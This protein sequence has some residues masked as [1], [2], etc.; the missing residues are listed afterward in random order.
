MN[1]SQ[2]H[3]ALLSFAVQG[4]VFL[5]VSFVLWKLAE[6]RQSAARS[7]A[8]ARLIMGTSLLLLIASCFAWKSDVFTSEE[9]PMENVASVLPL[10][11]YRNNEAYEQRIALEE[12]LPS[13]VVLDKSKQAVESVAWEASAKMMS[14]L[15]WIWG[16]GVIVIL[17][18]WLVAIILR[19]RLARGAREITETSLRLLASEFYRAP[20]RVRLLKS[21]RA[22]TPCAYGILTPAIL[23]PEDSIA[24]SEAKLRMV[25]AHECEHLNRRDPFWQM[26]GQIFLAMHWFNPFAWMLLR[27]CR[28]ANERAA[29]DAVLRASSNAASYAE[30]LLGFARDWARSG[31]LS[32]VVSSMASQKS[33]SSRVEAILDDGLD[34]RPFSRRSRALYAITLLTLVACVTTFISGPVEALETIVVNSEI[35]PSSSQTADSKSLVGVRLT[36]RE[37]HSLFP[38]KVMSPEGDVHKHEG[39]EQNTELGGR[40]VGGPQVR[41]S[42]SLPLWDWLASKKVSVPQAAGTGSNSQSFSWELASFEGRP[43]V[44]V[45]QIVQFY[46]A[47]S[48]KAFMDANDGGWTSGSKSVRLNGGKFNLKYPVQIKDQ[49]LWL[50]Q[51]DLTTLLNPVFQP[52]AKPGEVFNTV[53]I[54]PGHGGKDSG[55]MSKWGKEST[56]TLDTAKRLQTLLEAKGLKVVLARTEDKFTP[57]SERTALAS[58]QSNSIYVAI[59]FNSGPPTAA[60]LTT[61]A[62]IP[63]T[64]EE[65]PEQNEARSAQS[66]HLAQSVQA[67]CVSKLSSED[68]GISA[69]NWTLLTSSRLPTIL[70]EAGYLT[71]PEEGKKISTPEYRQ[72]LAAALCDGVLAYRTQLAK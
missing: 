32:S 34:R 63:K 48:L 10:P 4:M 70:V 2:I 43:Y 65:T 55:A 37:K 14:A 11:V 22:A 25:M 36:P 57:S 19:A 21:E 24:W 67:N 5:A 29:D 50:A 27:G 28:L 17:A 45:D 1:N 33:V 12:A 64:T 16:I 47:A 56:F 26:M 58:A 44:S 7:S 61:M 46:K 53:V 51:H 72:Q 60:G 15:V 39:Y 54:D 35:A 9:A 40:D 13:P 20:K 71:N 41:L 42:V 66:M 49:K 6:Q 3:Q 62:V 23:L 68:D 8:L 18:Q 31:R 52:A 30:L 59:H 38:R 69:V